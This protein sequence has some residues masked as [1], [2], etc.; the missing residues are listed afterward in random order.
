MSPPESTAQKQ[1]ESTRA[2]HCQGKCLIL[3]AGIIRVPT[4]LPY[5]TLSATSSKR[6]HHLP[7]CPY[8]IFM[9]AQAGDAPM[10]I[11]H[12]DS[13]PLLSSTSLSVRLSL[14]SA[15]CVP[16]KQTAS[17]PTSSHAPCRP[18]PTPQ[19]KLNLLPPSR[20]QE[21]SQTCVN[22]GQASSKLGLR[23]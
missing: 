4:T 2:P 9:K 1:E 10:C 7:G 22:N 3:R 14:R 18:P 8:S 21:K 13:T 20:P 23:E 12:T 19:N 5:C 15:S 16:T 11:L 6:A 17:V